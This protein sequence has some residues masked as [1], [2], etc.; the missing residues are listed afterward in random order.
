MAHPL[1]DPPLDY[2]RLFNALP[3]LYLILSPGF[4]IIEASDAYLAA[5]MTRL[6]DIIGRD[7]FDVFPD[8]PDQAQADGVSNLRASLERV[9]DDRVADTMALQRYDIRR[10]STEGG[11]FEER[12]WS[13][14]NAPVLDDAG[15]LQAIVHRV[16]DVTAYVRLQTSER[17][18]R[19]E[20]DDLR[21]HAGRMEAEIFVR[22]QEI[23][24]ANREL[25]RLNTSL[26]EAQEA[27]ELLA[28][29]IV[30]DLRNP[31]TAVLGNLEMLERKWDDLQ[32]DDVRYLDGARVGTQRQ[33]EMVNGII[34]VMRLEDGCM[35]A[36]LQ[37]GVDIMT[38]AAARVDEYRVMAVRA[39]VAIT[40]PHPGTV[41]VMRTDA[42]LLGRVLDNLIVNAIKHTPRGGSVTV[43]VRPSH[44]AQAGTTIAVTDTGEGIAPEDLGRLF[45]KYG[46]IEGQRGRY[47]Y[48]TGLGLLFCRMAVE[49]LGGSIRVDSV[50]QQGSTFTV[51]LPQ[52]V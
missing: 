42:V 14:H 3:G 26:R 40:A 50:L 33:L 30:H 25:Q 24:R 32:R 37:E 51:I 44:G 15:V 49:L 23:A 6:A 1:C 29:M 36:N 48:D 21:S 27:R 20:V 4:T 39:E 52:P 45:R 17:E 12:F 22:S 11:G 5:T 18:R 19:Q 46:R 8:N 9:R 28:G 41:V 7:I 34:D 2:R 38:L 35:R 13:P 10:P 47:S 16:E 43:A 31:L